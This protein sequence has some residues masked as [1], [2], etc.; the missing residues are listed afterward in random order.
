MP[1][2][3]Y[4][5][6]FCLAI[7]VCS[8]QIIILNNSAI[9]LVNTKPQNLANALPITPRRSCNPCTMKIISRYHRL[10][11][12]DVK[13]TTEIESMGPVRFIFY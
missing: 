11:I 8:I 13:R 3:N 9:W 12:Y 4:K 10:L 7:K 6:Q 2:R 5:A 1:A